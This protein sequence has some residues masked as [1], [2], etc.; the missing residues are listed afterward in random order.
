MHLQ[1]HYLKKDQKLMSNPR[2]LTVKQSLKIM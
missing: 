2:S 1:W